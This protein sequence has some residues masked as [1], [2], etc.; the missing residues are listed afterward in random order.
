[1]ENKNG[2]VAFALLGLAVGTAAYYLLGTE[3]G[4]RQLDRANEGVKSLTN[5]IK[6][7]SKKEAKRA[8]KLAKSAKADLENLK[9]KAKEAGKHA[10]DNASEKAQ[11]WANK[12]SDAANG[13]SHK[14][15]D[16]IADAKS[17]INKA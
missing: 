8:A 13:V 4:K 2:L 5:S 1:M 16:V 10:L 15:E 6:D 9:D 3:D 12:A 14:A 7:L 17:E 11:Q